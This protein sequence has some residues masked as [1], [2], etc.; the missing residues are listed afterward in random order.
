[1]E[2]KS[3]GGF[4]HR[5]IFCGKR[6]N[7]RSRRSI[8]FISSDINCQRDPFL[9]HIGSINDHGAGAGNAAAF[10]FKNQGVSGL[11]IAS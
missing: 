5:P 2:M 11:K 6:I 9:I 1:M 10:L 4:A 3:A 7:R 8:D